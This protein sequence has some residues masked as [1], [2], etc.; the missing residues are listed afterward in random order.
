MEC[1]VFGA[2]S[3]LVE[4]G[5]VVMHVVDENR[6]ELSNEEIKYIIGITRRMLK[7]TKMQLG[8]IAHLLPEEIPQETVD[9]ILRAS[10]GEN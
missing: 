6:N 10:R 8:E 2:D 1:Q 5:A 9:R 3:L 4:I 7:E